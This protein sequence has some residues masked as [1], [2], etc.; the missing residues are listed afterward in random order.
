MMLATAMRKVLNG[1]KETIGSKKVALDIL[2]GIALEYLKV[3]T[4]SRKLQRELDKLESQRKSLGK[5]L[6]DTSKQANLEVIETATLIIKRVDS[7]SSTITK[8]LLLA[9]G[10][11][12]SVIDASTDHKP[13]SYP[14]IDPKV[15]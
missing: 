1:T 3:Q 11:E 2:E 8:A 14:R 15:E 4:Q 6:C 5:V 7:H 13:Y 12:L 9:N 10:V